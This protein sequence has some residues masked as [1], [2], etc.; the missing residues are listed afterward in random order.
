MIYMNCAIISGNIICWFSRNTFGRK[1]RTWSSKRESLAI[2]IEFSK[3]RAMTSITVLGENF[4]SSSPSLNPKS[5][6]DFCSFFPYAYVSQQKGKK[7]FPPVL[8]LYICIRARGLW[9]H[10][11]YLHYVL[12]YYSNSSHMSLFYK[13]NFTQNPSPNVNV[14]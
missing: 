5:Y 3:A 7:V 9:N 14:F 4:H 13:P 8:V 1:Y 12:L 2:S 10:G 6:D 11:L